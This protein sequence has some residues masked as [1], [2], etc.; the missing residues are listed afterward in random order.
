MQLLLAA[1]EQREIFRLLD[2]VL[3][4]RA[5]LAE[6]RVQL[7]ADEIERLGSD[8]SHAVDLSRRRPPRSGGRVGLPVLVGGVNVP[9]R[10]RAEHGLGGGARQAE[11]RGGLAQPGRQ[12]GELRDGHRGGAGGIRG[13]RADFL[14]HLHVARDVLRGRGLLARAAG[15]VLHQARDL[16]RDLLDLLERRA[17]VLGEQRA[18]HHVRGAAFHRDHGLVGVGLNGAHQHFDLLGRVRGALG[19]ALHFVRDHRE[20][21]ARLAGHRGL[22]RGV[23]RE[24]VGLL[25]DVVDQLDD[26]ADLLRALAQALDALGGLLDGLADRVHAV[27]RAPHGIAALVR[28]FDRVP[29]DVRRA[30]GVA[31]HFLGRAGHAAGG[32][33]GRGD[34]LRLRAARLRE[35]L[36]QRLRLARPRCRA[37]WRTG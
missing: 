11:A 5:R 25:G 2:V 3:E 29:R 34:L 16:V 22:D 10:R 14:Q 15:D 27:D 37:G 21:A 17:R 8:V 24:N 12:L 19:E 36:R 26:V 18:A 20:A 31:G 35:M 23:E 13:L 1:L 33:G 28:D 7:A 4:R 32:F 30:L 6:R 9:V